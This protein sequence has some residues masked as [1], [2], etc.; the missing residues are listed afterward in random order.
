MLHDRPRRLCWMAYA[1]RPIGGPPATVDKIVTTRGYLNST[2]R[3]GGKNG[4][5]AMPN[6][7]PHV[8]LIE[9]N[10]LVRAGQRMLLEHA[11][12]R[13]AEIIADADLASFVVPVG[14]TLVIIADFDLGP[15]MT[16]IEVALEIMRRAGEPIPTLVLSASFGARSRAAAAACDMPVMVKPA[17]EERVLAW[18]AD[19]LGRPR[20]EPTS[21]DEP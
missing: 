15:G 1:V 18:V 16:G 11:G 19:A 12:Y 21:R 17:P 8:I 6:C 14:G 20:L 10:P 9:D 2:P 5:Q 13:V 4:E 3:P 7:Q